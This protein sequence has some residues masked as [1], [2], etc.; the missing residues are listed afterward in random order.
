[1]K[2][3]KLFSSPIRTGIT[4]IV[5]LVIITIIIIII[6]VIISQI[7]V[8]NELKKNPL[9]KSL[10]N[11]YYND[12]F[13]FQKDDFI[14]N[15]FP[16]S[17]NEQNEFKLNNNIN[18][19]KFE[20]EVYYVNYGPKYSFLSLEDAKYACSDLNASLATEK[21]IRH[22]LF[23][24]GKSW[25][26]YGWTS[27]GTQLYPMRPDLALQCEG[28]SG[29]VYRNYHHHHSLSSSSFSSSQS[30]LM[31]NKSKNKKT[32]TELP[33]AGA[34]CYGVKPNKLFIPGIE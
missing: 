29:I 3:K 27:E 19:L 25:C 4:I 6:M 1:M 28:K 24:K 10:I 20:P 14:Y 2:I 23:N 15:K 34:Y 5:I 26:A 9:P 12:S 8:K 7:H 30:L 21:Q 31:K 11:N 32:V 16:Y 22:S 18:S 17:W 33:P 13:Q